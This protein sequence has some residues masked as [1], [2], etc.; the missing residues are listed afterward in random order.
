MPMSNIV[1][2][3]ASQTRTGLAILLVVSV[4]WVGALY[5]QSATDKRETTLRPDDER[6]RGLVMPAKQVSLN[7]P[8]DGILSEITVEEGD[9]VKAGQPVARMDDA[10]QKVV[11]LGARLRSEDDSEIRRQTLLLAENNIQLDRMKDLAKSG[12]AQE[13]EVRRSQLQVDAT[14][15]ALDAATMQKR[16]AEENVK[17][18]QTRLSRYALT[19]PFDALVIRKHVEAGASVTNRDTVLTMVD[20]SSLEAQM[21]LPVEIFGKLERGRAYK[22][23]AEAPVGKTLTGKLKT[24]EPVI[25]SASQTFRCVFTIDNADEQLPAGFTVRLIWPQ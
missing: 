18:E 11:V 20:L 2:A 19:A 6:L 5:A 24:V 23:L 16:L 15:A 14:Q 25:D 7:A 4:G 9:H 1:P 17:L 8:M 3:S 21:F 22:L 13:W 12:S 10:I